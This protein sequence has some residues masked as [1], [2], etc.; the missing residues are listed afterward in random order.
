MLEGT[1]ITIL[2]GTTEWRLWAFLMKYLSISSVTL[3]LATAPSFMGLRVSILPGVRPSMHWASRPIAMISP[4][5]LLMATMVGSL[6][7]T[8]IPLT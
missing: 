3:G 7:T 5:L 4:V 6:T 2:G 8:P 1:A